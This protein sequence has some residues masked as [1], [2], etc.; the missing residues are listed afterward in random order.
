MFFSFEKFPSKTLDCT[1][2]SPLLL[3]LC[4][5]FFTFP[6]FLTYCTLLRCFLPLLPLLFFFPLLCSPSACYF[7]LLGWEEVTGLFLCPWGIERWSSL[8]CNP[9]FVFI[10]VSVLQRQLAWYDDSG[11]RTDKSLEHLWATVALEKDG[12]YHQATDDKIE[13]KLK[14]KKTATSL[15]FC[16]Q[17]PFLNKST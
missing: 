1:S 10:V 7:F 15:V 11:T 5:S 4:L 8:S 6:P 16:I 12:F 13:A 9:F 14:K 17:C 2:F 3:Q